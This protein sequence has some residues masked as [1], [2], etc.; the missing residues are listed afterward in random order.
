MLPRERVIQVIEHKK[1]DRVPIYAWVKFNLGD[2]VKEAYGS[3]E[4]FEDRYEF[5]FSHIFGGPDHYTREQ[6]LRL[7]EE[8][9]KA[10]EPATLLE[11]PQPDPND[12]DLYANVIEQVKHHKEERGR[13][14]YV[15]TPGIFEAHNPVFG[16][17]N[18]LAWLLLFEDDLKK[19]YERQAKWNQIFAINCLDLGVDMIHISDDWGSQRGLMFNPDLWWKMIYPYHKS[20]CDLVKKRGGYLSLHSDGDVNSVLDGIV[21]L[22]FDVVHPYQ[23]SAGMDLQ[24]FK[25]NYA[26]TF[27]AMG[28]LDVQSTIGFG[29]LDFLQAEIERVLTLFKDGGGLYC[30]THMI[31]GHCSIEELRFAFDHIYEFIRRED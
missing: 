22:G 3:V 9:N 20:T 23:E 15:Q 26:Q 28:G 12:M 11:E 29:K 16:I 13:F 24:D 17:E 5:D 21:D 14:V 18:H 4:A 2:T 30:T 25:K 6:I 1:P 27:T 19:V 8:N 31:Q 7:R 10:V